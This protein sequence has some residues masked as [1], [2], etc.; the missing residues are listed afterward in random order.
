M[1][2]HPCYIPSEILELAVQRW[3]SVFIE[4]LGAWPKVPPLSWWREWELRASGVSYLIHIAGAIHCSLAFS[5]TLTRYLTTLIPNKSYARDAFRD[6]QSRKAMW[7][8]AK[9]ALKIESPDTQS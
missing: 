8:C 1:V 2:D 6:K 7:E 9:E 5:N 3:C 4:E